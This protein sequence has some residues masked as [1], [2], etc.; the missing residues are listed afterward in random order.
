MSDLDDDRA[1][2]ARS[3]RFPDRGSRSSRTFRRRRF[4]SPRLSMRNRIES[5][6]QAGDDSRD[7]RIP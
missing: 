3:A 4:Q 2:A 7:H 1:V 6:K 5:Q